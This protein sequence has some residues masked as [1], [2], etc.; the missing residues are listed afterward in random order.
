VLGVFA[1]IG[2]AL[3]VLPMAFGMFARAPKGADMI[4]GFRP[5]MTTARLAGYQREI[6]EID[7]GVRDANTGAAAA[8]GPVPRRSQASFATRFPDVVT[9]GR[10]WVPIDTSLTNMLTTIQANLGNYRAVAALPNFSLF[11]WFFVIPG[12]AVL[13]MV[14]MAAVRPGWWTGLRWALVVLGVGLVLAP[15]A[16]RMFT[17]APAGGTMVNAFRT[18]ETPANV[19]SIQ[20][21]FGTI[22]GGEGAIQL[23]LV[24]ALHAAG[25]TDAQIAAR[26]PG[27]AALEHDWVPILNDLT[28]M[29]GAMSDNIVNY[30][31]VAALPPFRLFPWF[32]VLPGLLIA[33]LALTAT[34]RR[35]AGHGAALAVPNRQFSEGEQ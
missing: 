8:L 5:Y 34:P 26:F 27:I 6:R 29:I 16:F 14:G 25:L 18:I 23:E 3:I 12:V 31:A 21:D 24:P 28:P 20:T 2:V 13:V 19:Q 4:A 33:V 1:I 30:Q 10:Q 11:P 35:R 22:A 7:A 32:F 17:R 9:F 15:V